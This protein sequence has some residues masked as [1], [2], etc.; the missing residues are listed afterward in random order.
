[1]L[2]R[3]YLILDGKTLLSKKLPLNSTEQR[4]YYLERILQSLTCT[5]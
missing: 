3:D 1:M 2:N 4:F 5:L